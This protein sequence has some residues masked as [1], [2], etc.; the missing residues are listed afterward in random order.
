MPA[1]EKLREVPATSD[2]EL[3]LKATSTIM[4]VLL[5]SRKGRTPLYDYKLD[6][7]AYLAAKKFIDDNTELALEA[8]FPNPEARAQIKK[9]IGSLIEGE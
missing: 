2:R 3:L 4:T 6:H 9:F 7:R 5:N 1:I 8:E